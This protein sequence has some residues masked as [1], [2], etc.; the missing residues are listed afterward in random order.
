MA[1]QK[2]QKLKNEVL[3]VREQKII[4]KDKNSRIKAMKNIFMKHY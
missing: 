3:T 1:K 4:G 2:K